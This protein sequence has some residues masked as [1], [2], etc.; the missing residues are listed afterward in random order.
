VLGDVVAGALSPFVPDEAIAMSGPH[1]GWRIAG[2]APESG[3]YFIDYESF[4]GALGATAYADGF[5][6][7]RIWASGASNAPM[8]TL[9]AEYPFL[10]HRYELITDSGGAGR[11]RG[12]M[13]T[14]R[15]VQVF[16]TNLRATFHGLRHRVV[17]RGRGGGHPGAGG[18]FILNPDTERE[19]QLPWFA[20][21]Y[22]I[23][24]GDVLSVRT[25]G[26]GGAGDPRE[27]E[28]EA[29]MRDLREDRISQETAQDVYGFVGETR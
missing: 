21:R 2:N 23:E 28:R 3:K 18:D 5:D 24:D 9:E 26:G 16:G 11:Y 7:V 12:G 15:D 10:H 29:V 27:R 6:A 1:H 4:A 22:P 19:Q 25:P 20:T 17:A 8:E 13:G 14:R